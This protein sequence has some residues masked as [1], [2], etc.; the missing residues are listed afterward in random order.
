MIIDNAISRSLKEDFD[1]K[2]SFEK[3]IKNMTAPNRIFA[4][5]IRMLHLWFV[6]LSFHMLL[7]TK[8]TYFFF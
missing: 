4:F 6:N 2:Y 1:E 7:S 5:E 3:Q 8:H